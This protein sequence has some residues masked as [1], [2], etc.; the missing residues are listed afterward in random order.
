MKG[1]EWHNLTPQQIWK[2]C[3]EEGTRSAFLVCTDCIIRKDAYEVFTELEDNEMK[4]CDDYNL[5]CAFPRLCEV[6]QFSME[7]ELRA[8]HRECMAINKKRVEFVEKVFP[9]LFSSFSLD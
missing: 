5:R 1:C 7:E 3:D 8:L 6:C 4:E 2:F 9:D